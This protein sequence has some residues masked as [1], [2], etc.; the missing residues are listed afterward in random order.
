MF[1]LLRTF[2]VPVTLLSLGLTACGGSLEDDSQESSEDEL[3]RLPKWMFFAGDLQNGTELAMSRGVRHVPVARLAD[4]KEGDVITLT[5]RHLGDSAFPRYARVT[6]VDAKF[7]EIDGDFRTG[8]YE[9]PRPTD[10]PRIVHARI[11]K[12]GTYYVVVGST[13]NYPADFGLSLQRIFREGEPVTWKGSYLPSRVYNGSIYFNSGSEDCR[14]DPA[15]N[16]MTCRGVKMGVTAEGVFGTVISVP[17]SP[18]WARPETRI[19]GRMLPGRFVVFTHFS[20]NHSFNKLAR[21]QI[22]RFE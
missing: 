5:A 3:R 7:R 9:P 8:A 1:Q 16:E 15:R 10:N 21:A 11:P 18:Y 6:L 19:E 13:D 22:V 14:Y 2:L 12:S 4:A 20:W 17:S